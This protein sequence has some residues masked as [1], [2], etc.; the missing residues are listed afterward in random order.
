LKFKYKNPKHEVTVIVW[1]YSVAQ[2][3]CGK[4]LVISVAL[5][6]PIG[7]GKSKRWG[8]VGGAQVIGGV[9]L[10]GIFGTPVSPSFFLLLSDHEVSGFA[11][12]QAN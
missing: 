6:G 7:G 2:G 10:K 5:L 9:P 3:L 8:L 1:V 11:L 12:P 4:G